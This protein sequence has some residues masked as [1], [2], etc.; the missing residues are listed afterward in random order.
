MLSEE[1]NRSEKTC[2]E[3]C[4]CGTPGDIMLGVGC[5]AVC[6]FGVVGTI[7]KFVAN[8]FFTCNT[9]LLLKQNVN[10]EYMNWN[11]NTAAHN[12]WT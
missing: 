5:V 11:R 1:W 7:H 4:G 12:L 6:F 2:A 10:S 9:T 8:V 3:L